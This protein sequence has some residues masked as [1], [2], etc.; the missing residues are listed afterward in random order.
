MRNNRIKLEIYEG[1][2]SEGSCCGPSRVSEQSVEEL[3]RM[4]IDRN[5]TVR[6]LEEKFQGIVEVSR[7]VISSRRGLMSYPERVRKALS[8]KGRASLPYVFIEGKLVTAGD[9]PSYEEFL[10]LL[11]SHTEKSETHQK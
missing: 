5:E 8:Q 11:D 2:P 7:D 10:A 4:L 3:R 6:R 1:D 9:F